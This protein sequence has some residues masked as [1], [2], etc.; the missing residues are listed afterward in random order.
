VEL[1]ERIARF[2]S[3][4]AALFFPTGSMANQGIVPALA[5]RDGVILSDERNHASLID[6]CRLSRARVEVYPHAAVDAVAGLL[7]KHAGAARRVIV[8]DAVFSMEGDLAPLREL[9]GLSTYHRAQLV[10]DDAHG[11]GIFGPR[12]RGT[13]EHLGLDRAVCWQTG[14]FGKAFGSMGGFVAARF[15]EVDFLRNRARTF[16]FT[17]APPP[18]LCAANVAAIDLVE[19]ADEERGRLWENV[20]RFQEGLRGMGHDLHGSESPIFSLVLGPPQAAVAASQKLLREGFFVPAIR[21]PTVPEGTSR[22]R[23]SVT[24]LHEPGHLDALLDALR[25]LG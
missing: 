3:T 11:T 17:T 21:P 9:N 1:E 20:R 12:G 24:A 23:V 5:G 6:A 25:R 18:P 13:L 22:L 16:A 8:T 4:E 2:K 7:R 10:V 19:K 14:N 15:E